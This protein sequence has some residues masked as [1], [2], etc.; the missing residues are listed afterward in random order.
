MYM[1][2]STHTFKKKKKANL[3][4]RKEPGSD[5]LTQTYVQIKHNAHEVKE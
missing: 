1:Q 2:Q 5:T 3:K 4:G